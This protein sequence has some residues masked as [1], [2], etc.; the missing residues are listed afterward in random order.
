MDMIET[1][2]REYVKDDIVYL[3]KYPENAR[4]A[5]CVGN[6]AID[7]RDIISYVKKTEPLLL[8]QEEE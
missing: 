2:I 7:L 4:L 3:G 1:N 6:K 8:E 5:L